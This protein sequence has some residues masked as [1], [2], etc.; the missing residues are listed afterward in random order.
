[1]LARCPTFVKTAHART[2]GVDLCQ[3]CTDRRQGAPVELVAVVQGL[4]GSHGLLR[5]PEG[6][7]VVQGLAG[8]RN[9]QQVDRAFAPRS[10]R[11]YPQ[12]WALAVPVDSVLVA[13]ELM[14]GL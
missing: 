13:G 3:W 6:H 10:C 1:M 12:A 7:D 9:F 5:G 8:C 14:V 4:A 11:F 2:G